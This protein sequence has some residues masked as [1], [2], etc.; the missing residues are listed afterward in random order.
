V[1]PQA[2]SEAG[3]GSEVSSLENTATG[4]HKPPPKPVGAPEVFFLSGG[5]L[6]ETMEDE[7][8]RGDLN[9]GEAKRGT[10]E[11]ERPGGLAAGPG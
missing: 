10:S 2:S 8:R 5:D 1:H 3:Q 9:E 6:E 7:A 4:A 11:G